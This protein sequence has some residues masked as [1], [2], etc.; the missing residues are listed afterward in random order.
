M[1]SIINP[2][3]NQPSKA[4]VNYPTLNEEIRDVLKE[5]EVSRTKETRLYANVIDRLRSAGATNAANAMEILVKHGS[6]DESNNLLYI[7][8]GELQ[9]FIDEGNVNSY[10]N[11]EVPSVPKINEEEKKKLLTKSKKVRKIAKQLQVQE[12]LQS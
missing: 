2:T 11:S 8:L 6:L 12:S 3:L 5:V 4:V 1:P 10:V 9:K 7:L